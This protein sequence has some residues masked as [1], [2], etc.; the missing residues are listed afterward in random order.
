MNAHPNLFLIGAE[1]GG[2]TSVAF[3]LVSHP[4]IAFFSQKEPNFFIY[5]SVAEC[6]EAMK[7]AKRREHGGPYWLDASVN[8][9]KFPQYGTVPES[10]AA[11]CGRDAPRILYMMRNPVDR[12]VSHYFWRRERYGED[13][14][15][16][17]VMQE[18]SQYILSSRYDLQIE[19][20]QSIFAPEQMRFLVF[21]HY[22]ANV[23][24]EYAEICRWLDLDD[25]HEPDTKMARGGTNKEVSRKPRMPIVNRIARSSPGLRQTVRKLLPHKYQLQLTQALSKEVPREEVGP[26]TRA[27]LYGFFEES[28]KRTEE[29]TGH[30]LSVWKNK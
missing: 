15:I 2:S 17:A 13:R 9:S 24:T 25:S 4:G 11:V 8:Y 20:Y 7:N 21:D 22:F 10:I 29:L 3:Q 16:E 23:A 28:I 27:R 26:E 30:D 19:R 12:A 5:S 14:S 18:D 6:Q 1:K